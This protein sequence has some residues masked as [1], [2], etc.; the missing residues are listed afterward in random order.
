[1]KFRAAILG[2]L[3]P[4]VRVATGQ[5][6]HSG[7]PLCVAWSM[8]SH[9]KSYLAR[10][11]FLPGYEERNLGRA[12]FWRL[13]EF[14]RSQAPECTLVFIEAHEA[15]V[16]LMGGCRYFSVPAWVWGDMDVPIGASVAR[17][18][19]RQEGY[20]IRK[21]QLQV[22]VTRDPEKVRH[23]H[24]E[25][26]VPTTLESHGDGAYLIG[27]NTL[28][29]WLENGDLLMVRNAE[30]EIGGMVLS[31]DG[32][33]PLTAFPGVLRAD[34]RFLQQGAMG[35]L[36]L[37]CVERAAAKGYR[38][39]N[40]GRSRP[41]LLDGVMQYKKKLGHR[42]VSATSTDYALRVLKLSGGAVEFLRN[43]PFIYRSGMGLCGATF[44]SAGDGAMT[45][46]LYP[47]LEKMVEYRVAE[48][49]TD[50]YPKGGPSKAARG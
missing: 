8:G 45:M 42:I 18:T 19:K 34:R 5:E 15:Q 7:L 47:G 13:E 36:Y 26:Y 12:W 14:V 27:L 40:L 29:H 48:G 39:L 44:T 20:R 22:D 37:C 24:Q 1:V 41:F 9:A 50:V 11:A 10:T 6:R 31:Y 43:N 16:R 2:Q 33:N 28:H 49:Q 25:M 17:E 35:A 30:Q 32:G 3:R 21:Y 4:D 23:F 46:G 38:K